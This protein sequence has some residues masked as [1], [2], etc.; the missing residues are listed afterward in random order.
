V[1]AGCQIDLNERVTAACRQARDAA[2]ASGG[3]GNHVSDCRR[4]LAAPDRAKSVKKPDF[5]DNSQK[6]SINR[7]FRH[8]RHS[9]RWRVGLPC[10]AQ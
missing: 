2:L 5:L 3:E 8:F 9:A 6:L 7:H 4:G 1:A 10:I